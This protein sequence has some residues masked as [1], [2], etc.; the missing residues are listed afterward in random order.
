MFK[1]PITSLIV[2]NFIASYQ[3]ISSS[4]TFNTN[5]PF[6]YADKDGVK[7]VTNV[8]DEMNDCVDGVF[9]LSMAEDGFVEMLAVERES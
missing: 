5:D 4:P 7:L 8:V 9:A 1:A 3:S 6:V 2:A